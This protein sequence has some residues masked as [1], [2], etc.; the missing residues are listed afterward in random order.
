VFFYIATEDVR[1][2][3]DLIGVAADQWGCRRDVPGE[4]SA[5]A[6]T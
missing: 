4:E 1:W 2:F 3:L 5:D 6:F